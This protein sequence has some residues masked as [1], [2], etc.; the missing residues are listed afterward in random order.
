MAKEE[1]ETPHPEH[2][3]I[4]ESEHP[5]TV[6]VGHIGETPET[7]LSVGG[8]TRTIRIDEELSQIAAG[9]PG[10]WT[11]SPPGGV[12]MEEEEEETVEEEA[13]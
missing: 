5:T 8:G 3:N 1:R 12:G 11:T 6:G 2:G 4:G 9:E 13:L 10:L 7:E